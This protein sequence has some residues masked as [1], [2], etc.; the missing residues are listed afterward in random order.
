MF[1]L[2]KCYPIDQHKFEFDSEGVKVVHRATGET[3][4][5]CDFS[6]GFALKAENGDICFGT[7]KSEKLYSASISLSDGGGIKI[8]ADKNGTYLVG[9]NHFDDVGI[10]Q[11]KFN[12]STCPVS[13]QGKDSNVTLKSPCKSV[14]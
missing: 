9:S 13:L 3:V 7:L 8:L 14:K 5:N 10:T 2:E 4:D 12:L 1:N 11:H 6:E